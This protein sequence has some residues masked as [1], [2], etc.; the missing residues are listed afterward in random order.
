MTV[1]IADVV[2]V[3]G[4]GAKLVAAEGSNFRMVPIR[5]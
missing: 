3:I 5:L 1:I 2:V 4:E